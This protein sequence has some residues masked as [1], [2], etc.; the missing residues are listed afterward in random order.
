[1][2]RIIAGI[3]KGRTL[4][5]PAA[6]TRPTSDRVRESIFNS[7]QHEL[8]SWQDLRVLDLYA[9]SGAFGL[10][11]MSRGAAHSVAI[12][13]H[14]QACEVIRANAQTTNFDVKVIQREVL[15]YVASPSE[16]QFDVVF[17]DPP[18]EVSNDEIE[19]VLAA[20]QSGGYLADDAVI[21]VERS[22]RTDAPTWPISLTSVSERTLGETRV[23]TLVC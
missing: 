1:M 20:L 4:K 11:A 16:T 17:I 23:F 2:T 3:A 22:A 9:G 21:V 18:Y 6:G 12:E 19:L 5:V 8:G 15:K 14:R 7:L 10:E 13:S